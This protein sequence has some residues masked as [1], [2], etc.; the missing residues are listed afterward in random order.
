VTGVIKVYDFLTY[1][2]RLVIAL[3]DFG[4]QSLANL[5]KLRPIR[6]SE[7]LPIAIALVDTLGQV[8]Q[9]QII[10]KDI[11][12]ANM[13]YNSKTGE[14]KLIDFGIANDLS[15]ERTTLTVSKELRGTLAYISPEQ[16]GRMNRIVDYRT[17]LYSLGAT[18]YELLTEQLPFPTNDTM[19][20]VHAHIAKL[21]QP[22]HERKLSVPQPLSDI[23]LK[24]MAKKCGRSLSIH[25]WIKERF[26]R[27]LA[28]LEIHRTH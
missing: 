19:E 6:I 27:M 12:P 24:L 8:H 10:H 5:V 25:F 13:V 15:R 1:Q 9:H 7:F 11:N 4:G 14:V 2:N 3:E 23:V 18:F 28:S 21:P 22:P 26:G 20:L 16:T 17:D